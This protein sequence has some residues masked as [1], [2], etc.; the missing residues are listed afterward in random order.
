[1]STPYFDNVIKKAEQ[2]YDAGNKPDALALVVSTHSHA[3]NLTL[4]DDLNYYF[5]CWDIYKKD[6]DDYDKCIAY[7]DSMIRVLDN[8]KYGKTLKGKYVQV[9]NMKADALFAKELYNE[10]YDYYYRAKTMANENG[11]SCSMSKYSYSLGMALYRQQNYLNSAN[12]FIE[13]YREAEQCQDIFAFFYH[14][15]ELLDNIG[16]C[17]YKS[18]RYDRALSY[19]D[20]AI[21]Y[22][23]SNFMRFNK[24][25]NVF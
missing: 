17:Y 3:S 19:Y 11:D 13:S 10:S 7:S 6:L 4:I 18:Q 9:Y 15:Q 22:I 16:L 5:Y 12:Y 1:M 8:S 23:D 21:K 14:R 25:A 2:L 24:P 20:K